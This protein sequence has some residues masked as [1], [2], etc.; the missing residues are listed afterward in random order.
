M[1]ERRPIAI[2]SVPSYLSRLQDWNKLMQ[3]APVTVLVL[4]QACQICT[5][6][7][8]INWSRALQSYPFQPLSEFFLS[9]ISYAFC[10]GF[11]KFSSI[12]KSVCKNL[13]GALLHPSVVDEYLQA[14]VDSS[15]VAGPFTS[16]PTHNLLISRFGVIPKHNQPDRWRLIFNLSHPQ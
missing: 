12:L 1:Q 8:V 14:E 13:R 11:N 15:R 7:I 3:E 5:P 6:L 4:L 10:I 9:G 2:N 16:L